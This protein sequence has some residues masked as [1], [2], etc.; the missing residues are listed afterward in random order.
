M[1]LSEKQQEYINAYKEM[2]KASNTALLEGITELHN[3]LGD[4]KHELTTDKL[5][6]I[7]LK[8]QPVLAQ[9]TPQLADALSKQDLLFNK[10]EE[11][12]K[13][14]QQ[15]IKTEEA[16]EESLKAQKNALGAKARQDHHTTTVNAFNVSQSADPDKNVRGSPNGLHDSDIKKASQSVIN[17]I[18]NKFPESGD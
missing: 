15:Q 9:T 3:S 8:L 5:M 14:L 16:K 13:L 12:L 2:Y 6:N 1:A 10:E 18:D 17:Y 4:R 11:T 7:Y